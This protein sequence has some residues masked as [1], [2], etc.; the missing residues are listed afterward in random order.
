MLV[1]KRTAGSKGENPQDIIVDFT[2]GK[3]ADILNE[4][5]N[6]I[7]IAYRTYARQGKLP[8][9]ASMNDKGQVMIKFTD[10]VNPAKIDRQAA[11]KAKV[12]ALEKKLL[13]SGMSQEDVNVLLNTLK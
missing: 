5:M 8:A 9:W 1:T 6:S 3:E 2:D 10:Y 13:A 4:A 11:F 7:I 12:E